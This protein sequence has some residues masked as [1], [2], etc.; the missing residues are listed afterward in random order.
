[1]A[2]PKSWRDDPE[3]YAELMRRHAENELRRI[4][5]PPERKPPDV[6][7]RSPGGRGYFGPTGPT[8]RSE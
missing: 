6:K 3:L 5:E 8:P 1:M 2:K 4:V 7:Q